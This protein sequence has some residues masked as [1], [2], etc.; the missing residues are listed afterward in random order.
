MEGNRSVKR[1][2]KFYNLDMILAI[3]YRVRS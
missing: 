3:G 1:N 2:V